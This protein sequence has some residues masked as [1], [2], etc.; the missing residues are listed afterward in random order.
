MLVKWVGGHAERVAI[1]RI[2]ED[3]WL[4]SGPVRKDIVL[5]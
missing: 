3:V 5:R 1:A 2:H 4:A